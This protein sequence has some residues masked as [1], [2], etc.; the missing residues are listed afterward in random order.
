MTKLH[1]MAPRQTGEWRPTSHLRFAVPDRTTT[2]PPVLQQLWAIDTM[3]AFG[4]IIGYDEEWRPVERA[5]V[6]QTARETD[7]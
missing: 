5:V 4:H 2:E 7:K 1:P 3:N 6:E